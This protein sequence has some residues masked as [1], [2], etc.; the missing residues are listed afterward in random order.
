[1]AVSKVRLRGPVWGQ[2]VIW[3][4]GEA[5]LDCT[6]VFGVELNNGLST[7]RYLDLVL[8]AE[9]GHN[10]SVPLSVNAHTRYMDHGA[11]C[12]VVWRERGAPLMLLEPLR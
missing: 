5:H 9:A 4:E 11:V 10:C 1:M 12:C 8:G 6:C 3:R 7:A 2:K